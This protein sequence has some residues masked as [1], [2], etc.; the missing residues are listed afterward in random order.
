MC[1]DNIPSILINSWDLNATLFDGDVSAGLVPT[2][3]AEDADTTLKAIAGDPLKIH[4]DIQKINRLLFTPEGLT[5]KEALAF[6]KK[7]R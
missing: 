6:M 1:R 2:L 5:L 7:P 3:F 4:A